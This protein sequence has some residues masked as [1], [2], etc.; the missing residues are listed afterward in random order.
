MRSKTKPGPLVFNSP[1][2]FETF[3]FAVDKGKEF[4]VDIG[5]H[6]CDGWSEAGGPWLRPKI[7]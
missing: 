5:I 3:K 4:G 6:N 7:P 2:W 1:E